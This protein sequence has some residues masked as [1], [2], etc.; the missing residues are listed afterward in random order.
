MLLFHVRFQILGKFRYEFSVFVIA[1]KSARDISYRP[2]SAIH[3][4]TEKH[5]TQNRFAVFVRSHKSVGFEKFSETRPAC[6]LL[7][8]AVLFRK[9]VRTGY[10]RFFKIIH[11]LSSFR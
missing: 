3:G 2:R 8:Y 5:T 4:Q 7:K 1:D 10:I 6:G 9:F 11:K